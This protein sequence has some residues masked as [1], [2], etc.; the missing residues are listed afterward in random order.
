[1]RLT[2]I[3][4]LNFRGVADS[5]VE[6][7]EGVTVIEGPNEVGKSS[8][9]EAIR[10]IR[11][12]KQGS[13][14]REV[15][16]V[17]PVHKDAGP[18]VVLELRTG[19]FDL[20][21]RKRWLKAP[22]AELSIRTPVPENLTGD[23]AHDRFLR[24]LEETLDVDLLEAL[25]VVQGK[26][27]D[28]P[29]LADITALQRALSDSTGG[30]QG[31]D[32]LAARIDAEYS[33]YFTNTGR[34]T[35]DYKKLE[36]EVP[37]LEADLEDQAKRS[38]EAD[39]FTE[40]HARLSGAL[41]ELTGQL[42]EAK[43]GLQELEKD[44]GRLE[45]LREAG[46]KAQ[47]EFELA[48]GAFKSSAAATTARADLVSDLESRTK[49]LATW[50]GRIDANKGVVGTAEAGFDEAVDTV[51]AR[52]QSLRAAQAAARAAAAAIQARRDRVDRADILL[53][54][55]QAREAERLRAVAAAVLAEAGADDATVNALASLETELRLAEARR[56]AASARVRVRRLSST[57]VT[58]DGTTLPKGGDAEASVSDVVTVVADGVLTVEVHPGTPPA[59]LDRDVNAAS[60]SL[61]AALNAAGV[62]SVEEARDV[63]AR[64]R[65][66][67]GERDSA[68]A[69]LQGIVGDSSIKALEELLAGVE[70]RIEISGVPDDNN[71]DLE[72]FESALKDA[73]QAEELAEGD[74]IAAREVLERSR[75]AHSVARDESLRA[76][77]E[78]KRAQEECDKAASSLALA[79]QSQSDDQIHERQAEA[80]K[81]LTIAEANLAAAITSLEAAG[82][83]ALE[84][85]LKNARQLVESK[86]RDRDATR[87]RVDELETLISDRMTR[88]IYDDKADAEAALSAARDSLERIQRA[89]MAAQ[90]LK[91]TVDRHRGE[92]QQKYVAP[93]KERIERLG[94]VVFGPDFS[95]QVSQE[96]VIE[97]RTLDGRTVPF[98]SLSAGTREQLSL[99]GRLACAQL[100]DKEEGTPVILDDTLGFADPKRLLSLSVVLNDVGESAQ[101]ILLTCQPSRFASLGGAHVVRLP[102]S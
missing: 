62:D 31:H 82:S 56:T 36:T 8:I 61:R 38:S 19:A 80:K 43:S 70:V 53:R 60:A 5:T 44:A 42:V 52:E 4:L 74:L 66:A 41:E 14:H 65:A 94:K 49:A 100:V 27:L 24:V 72:A 48:E 16:S 64:R 12:A 95:V 83:D 76:D 88:G 7:S 97:S 32:S 86:Q 73:R 30:P 37:N 63:A 29:R 78:L 57:A 13:R 81:A 79:R 89:A 17:Q 10:L 47:H 68:Q 59:D 39:A 35:S 98:D 20:T 25:D 87:K 93:F 9:A 15:M 77:V 102:V 21:Y 45:Q 75:T 58:L 55:E 23:A 51:A 54:L 46:A 6:F 28:Q 85:H 99:L 22:I 18:E 101:V 40:D 84:M 91:S 1:M 96:L 69:S 3:T 90:L 26:S 71:A 50:T 67:E 92:A 33:S 2:R 34:S 11:N